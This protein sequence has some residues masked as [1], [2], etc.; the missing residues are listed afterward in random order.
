MGSLCMLLP[1]CSLTDYFVPSRLVK[2]GCKITERNDQ[3]RRVLHK[4]GI[5]GGGVAII[6]VQSREPSNG[7]IARVQ[8]QARSIYFC[9][10]VLGPG[11]AD[12]IGSCTTPGRHHEHLAPRALPGLAEPEETPS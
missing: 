7:I 4:W 2:K 12:M 9:E 11:L 5:S 10:D 1:G 8:S 6:V 3:R